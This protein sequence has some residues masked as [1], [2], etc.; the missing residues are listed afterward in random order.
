M[1]STIAKEIPSDQMM[2]SAR[3]IAD[4]V[5]EVSGQRLTTMVCTMHRFVLAE[6]NTHRVFSR[7]SASSRAIPV[8]R[9]L[10]RLSAGTASPVK[11]PSE[12]P[13]MQ[14]GKNLTG[15]DKWGAQELWHDIASYTAEAVQEYLD[16][17]P[18]KSTRVHKSVINRLLEPFMWHTVIVS[19]TEWGNFF[20]QRVSL[21]AQPELALTARAM[22]VALESS[23]PKE[24]MVGEWHKPFIEPEEEESCPLLAQLA[25]S[26]ARCA[27]I[28]FLNHEGVRSMPDDMKLANRL[29]FANPRHA[30]PFEMPATPAVGSSIGN[31]E[32]FHQL[33]HHLTHAGM[34]E[35]F[36]AVL[37]VT[38]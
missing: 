6:F 18:D 38:A 14:G 28:S 31:F 2:P 29:Y 27:R 10:E 35:D 36:E 22:F 32:G 12:Q 1:T 13:G 17:H 23:T 24:L 19:S 5:S 26:T 21:L 37:N 4:S 25:A 7:S 15:T 8:E 3:V 30:A 34:A 20:D 16:S 11:W 33:R 9:Q